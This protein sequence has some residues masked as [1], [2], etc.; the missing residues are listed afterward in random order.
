MPVPSDFRYVSVPAPPFQVIFSD[1]AVTESTVPVFRLS[2]PVPWHSVR[3]TVQVPDS[4]PAVPLQT[5]PPVANRP[6]C[7]PVTTRATALPPAVVSQLPSSFPAVPPGEAVAEPVA[8]VEVEVVVPGV[9]EAP[10]PESSPLQAV[11][12]RAAVRARPRPSWC[13]GRRAPTSHVPPEDCRCR[14]RLRAEWAASYQPGRWG[15]WGCCAGSSRLVARRAR[16]AC[17]RGGARAA[18]SRRGGRARGNGS[19]IAHVF[20]HVRGKPASPEALPHV[21]RGPGQ[22]RGAV[23]SQGTVK[24]VTGGIPRVHVHLRMH[25]QVNGA[26]IRGS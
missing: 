10:S 1:V 22:T 8:A 24:A 2:S 19:G 12:A 26:M 14:C 18:V 23:V 20:P 4:L 13:G 3:C 5:V 21:G 11:R 7:F 25:L 6:A 17:A 9:A 16:P 15:G